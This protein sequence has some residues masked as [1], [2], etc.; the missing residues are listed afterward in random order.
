[1]TPWRFAAS[2]TEQAVAVKL[3]VVIAANLEELRHGR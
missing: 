2:L 3:N 1:M